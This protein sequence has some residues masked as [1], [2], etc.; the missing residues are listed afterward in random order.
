LGVSR[1]DVYEAVESLSREKRV[2][3]KVRERVLREYVK[4]YAVKLYSEAED[5][6]GVKFVF[7]IDEDIDK[8]I[9]IGEALEDRFGDIMFVGV[10]PK[11]RGIN[12]MVFVGRELREKG[13]DAYRLGKES[14]EGVLK[15]GGKG[16][17]RYARFGGAYKGD[18]EAL[19]EVFIRGVKGF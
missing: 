4:L 13:L 6:D 11:G 8:V 1:R 5:L 16:D 3:E 7:Y 19:R 15:G 10:S 12:I 9:K 14:V 2:V 18:L 17:S